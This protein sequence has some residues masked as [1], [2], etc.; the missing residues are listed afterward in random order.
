[1]IY[2]RDGS[3]EQVIMPFFPCVTTVLS[4]VSD[5]R[6]RHVSLARA[7]WT[8]FTKIPE[9]RLLFPPPSPK[10][11]V[12]TWFS[13]SYREW[14][15]EGPVE[16]TATGRTFAM[17]VLTPPGLAGRDKIVRRTS[18]VLYFSKMPAIVAII[19]PLAA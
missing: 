4:V 7:L 10:I 9:N 8:F 2:L 11:G 15:R 17:L 12:T 18:L 3:A 13:V 14:L 16:A 19:L 6:Q 1:V 5:L